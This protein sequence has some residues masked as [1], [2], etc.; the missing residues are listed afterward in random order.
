[1][2]HGPDID[3]VYS[4]ES[5]SSSDSKSSAKPDRKVAETKTAAPRGSLDK[6]LRYEK[7]GSADEFENS[8]PGSNRSRS[9][10]DKESVQQKNVSPHVGVD[11]SVRSHR[12]H[13]RDSGA[14]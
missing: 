13:S 6:E 3:V 10:S 5:N 8:S 7:F 12:S 9:Y 2:D 4:G 1:M 14:G 11:D